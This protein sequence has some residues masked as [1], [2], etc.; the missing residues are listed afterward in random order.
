MNLEERNIPPAKGE[1][2]WDK[3]MVQSSENAEKTV[4]VFQKEVETSWDSLTLVFSAR[5][6]SRKYLTPDR[7]NAG[8]WISWFLIMDWVSPGEAWRYRFANLLN[9][10]LLVVTLVVSL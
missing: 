1:S 2:T 4:F 8:E 5:W 3:S 9:L 7:P 10:K 6:F